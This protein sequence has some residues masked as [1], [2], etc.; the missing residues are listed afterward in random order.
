VSKLN[1]VEG[2]AQEPI[3]NIAHARNIGLSDRAEKNNVPLPGID[4]MRLMDRSR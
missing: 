4:G 1:S 2:K 3:R